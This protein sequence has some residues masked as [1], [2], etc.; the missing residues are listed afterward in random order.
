M[1]SASPAQGK[2]GGRAVAGPAAPGQIRP[3]EDALDAPGLD[4]LERR[5]KAAIGGFTA[6]ADAPFADASRL[7]ISCKTAP[8]RP[9]DKVSDKSPDF[10]ITAG[11]ANLVTASMRADLDNEDYPSVKLD[12]PSFGAAINAALVVIAGVHTLA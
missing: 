1:G 9:A 10:R 8:V 4:V 3:E 7:A 2:K 5:S 12:D 11:R 6:N